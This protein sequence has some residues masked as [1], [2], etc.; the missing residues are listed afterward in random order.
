VRGVEGR[1]RTSDADNQLTTGRSNS[2]PYHWNERQELQ[3]VDSPDYN[4]YYDSAGRRETFDAFGVDTS[5][6]YDSVFAAQSTISGTPGSTQNYLTTPGGDVLAYS[7]T[8]GSTTTTTVPLT[9]LLGSTLGMVNSSGSLATTFTYEPFGKP[10]TS[11]QTTTYPYLFAGMEYDAQTGLYH[12][13]A[14]YYSPTLQRFVSEDPL[15]F[16]GGDVNLFVYAGNDPVNRSDPLG[17]YSPPPSAYNNVAPVIDS[18]AQLG[19][20]FGI[21]G[22]SVEDGEAVV[23]FSRGGS[24]LAAQTAGFGGGCSR[25][26]GMPCLP[27]FQ[28]S[29]IRDVGGLVLA[30]KTLQWPDYTPAPTPTPT[31]E[32]MWKWLLR[33]LINPSMTQWGWVGSPSRR[34]AARVVAK[35]GEITDIGGKVPTFDEAKELIADTGGTIDRIHGPHTGSPVAGRIDYPHINYTTANGIKSHLAIQSLP[36]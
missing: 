21:V 1:P 27:Q 7:V 28:G 16:G 8:S 35:G 20:E 29:A 2:N 10:T 5:Y 23:T 26:G 17:L 13:P 11:G 18:A 4:F 6:L 19:P 15:G 36:P 31:T 22:V 30:Q 24:A 12:T 3:H 34:E 25:R 33:S 32:Y 9:D 14:R